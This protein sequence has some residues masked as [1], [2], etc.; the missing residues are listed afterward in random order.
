MS[1]GDE[2]DPLGLD[3][4]LSIE[5]LT[6][7]NT[8]DQLGDGVD[9]EGCVVHDYYPH[10]DSPN[11]WVCLNCRRVSRNYSVVEEAGKRYEELADRRFGGALPEGVLFPDVDR[12]LV[13]PNE[14]KGNRFHLV[15]EEEDGRLAPDCRQV[16]LDSGRC[17][18]EPISDWKTKDAACYPG[19]TYLPC[20]Y[21]WPEWWKAYEGRLSR[22][23]R[24]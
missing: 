2:P 8:G 7:R 15:D 14:G 9:P 22:E 23:G 13:S 16:V 10:P 20:R 6:E 21:C 17:R 12:V 18:T 24:L 5:D 1:V 4:D 19:H 11:M 3:P